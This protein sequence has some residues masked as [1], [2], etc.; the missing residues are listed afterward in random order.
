MKVCLIRADQVELNST[1]DRRS[2]SF[3]DRPDMLVRPARQNPIDEPSL[4]AIVRCVCQVVNRETLGLE[5]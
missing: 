2:M 4:S 1:N 3:T 5:A